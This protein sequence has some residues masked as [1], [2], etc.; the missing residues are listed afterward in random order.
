[1]F[2]DDLENFLNLRAAEI[3]QNLEQFFS[4]NYFK[5]SWWSEE[6][7]NFLNYTKLR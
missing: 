7:K 3:I 4:E 1:M 2:L 5:V 6:L